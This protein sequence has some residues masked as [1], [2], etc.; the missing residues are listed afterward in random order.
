MSI[1]NDRVKNNFRDYQFSSTAEMP[2]LEK[3]KEG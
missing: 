1:V 2:T 3:E